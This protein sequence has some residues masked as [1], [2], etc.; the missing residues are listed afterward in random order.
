MANISI[1]SA[2]PQRCAYCF[3]R[4]AIAG[5]RHMSWDVFQS[6]LDLLQRS[7][8]KQARLLGGEP[9]VHPRF[10]DMLGEI[11]RRGLQIFIFSSGYMAEKTV[12]RLLDFAP[13]QLRVLVNISTPP[14]ESRARRR[15]DRVLARLGARAMLGVNI[16]AAQSVH[17][18][19]AALRLALE[20]GNHPVIRIGL[21]HPTLAADNRCLHPKYY[22]FVGAA[23][24]R[25]RAAAAARGVRLQYDCGFVP[26]MFADAPEPANE[27]AHCGPIVD[28]LPDGA[29]V[30]CYALAALPG[31]HLGATDTARALR[32]GFARALSAYQDM[33][34]YRACRDCAW[35]ARGECARGCRAIVIKRQLQAGFGSGIEA[36]PVSPKRRPRA[37]GRSS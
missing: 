11:A 31:P 2:C 32:E 15:R 17:E 29:I 6:A 19:D 20:G 28:I 35:A 1:T 27:I 8:I 24:A 26:C 36:E 14:T 34:I 37:G 25:L 5:K 18:L 9:T 21:A 30:S 4:G 3:A 23:L 33:G 10:D 12:R 22:P 13:D 7:G 16:Q